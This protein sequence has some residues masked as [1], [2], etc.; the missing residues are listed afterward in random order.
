MEV[1][2]NG[3]TPILVRP[4]EECLARSSALLSIR[5]DPGGSRR[6]Q[7]LEGDI[8]GLYRILDAATGKMS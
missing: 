6:I 3:S 8:Q 7:I 5:V 1:T 2:A 4:F